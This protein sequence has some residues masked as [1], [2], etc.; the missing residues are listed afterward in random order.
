MYNYYFAIASD[1]FFLNQ[2][3]IEEVLRERTQYYQNCD[4]DIDFWFVLNP[5]FIHLLDDDSNF[6]KMPNSCA[7]IISLDKKFIQWLKLRV[8]F[9]HVGSFKSQSIFLP[10]V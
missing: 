10:N 7:A 9:V 1:S 6:L 8:V 2:E 5:G 3:P 4:K